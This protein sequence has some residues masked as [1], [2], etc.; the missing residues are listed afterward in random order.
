ML[1][2]CRGGLFRV[3]PR[4]LPVVSCGVLAWVVVNRFRKESSPVSQP[5]ESE[6]LRRFY[7]TRPS[8]N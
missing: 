7:H 3:L 5:S 1:A 8:V 4:L 2:I 6:R